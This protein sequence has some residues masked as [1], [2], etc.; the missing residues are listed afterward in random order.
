[1]AD[2]QGYCYNYW[3]LRMKSFLVM[4]LEAHTA[5]QHLSVCTGQCSLIMTSVALNCDI[6]TGIK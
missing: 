2:S 1:M 6:S 5:A 3:L 4:D